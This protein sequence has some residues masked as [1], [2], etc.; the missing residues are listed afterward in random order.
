M[1]RKVAL[2]SA[3]ALFGAVVSFVHAQTVVEELERGGA[4]SW[5]F[6]GGRYII[7]GGINTSGTIS[8]GSPVVFTFQDLNND[9]LALDVLLRIQDLLPQ[10][11]VNRDIPLFAQVISNNGDSAII[12]WRG[13]D[14]P[15]QCIQI[16]FGG[17]TLNVLITEL[18]GQLRGLVE[19]VSCQSDPLE[20]LPHNP[21]LRVTMIGGNEFNILRLRG[22]VFCVQVPQTFT[23]AEIV[24]GNWVAYGGGLPKSLG[25][26]NGDCVI[27][28]ADLLQVLFDF[29]GSNSASDTNEDGVVDDADLLTVLFNFG[30]SV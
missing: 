23:T 13:I 25:N 2:L 18:F 28:D 17:S 30:A 3:L 22:Y 4:V 19:R 1:S 7:S 11:G 26:V 27:D 29:G 21:H 6:L 5:Q 24:D 8:A 14:N 20:R 12:Q 9:G 15:N 10:L 16:E